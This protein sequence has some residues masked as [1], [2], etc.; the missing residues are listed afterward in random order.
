TIDDLLAGTASDS[1]ITISG[2]ATDASF[3][4]SAAVQADTAGRVFIDH[5]NSGD[6][7][8]RRCNTEK[9]ELPF[10]TRENVLTLEVGGIPA[11]GEVWTLTV[12]DGAKTYKAESVVGFRGSLATIADD[13]ADNLA[14]VD[15]PL[16]PL[17]FDI[18]IVGLVMVI[19]ALDDG[20]VQASAEITTTGTGPTT[21]IFNFADTSGTSTNNHG[22]SQVQTFL[23]FAPSNWDDA[24]T[25]IVAAIDDDFIDGGDALVFP[26]F[27]ERVNLI[28]GPLNVIGG[29]SEAGDR[30]INDPFGLPDETNFLL[31]EGYV[32]ETTIV[33]LDVPGFD[34]ND[35]IL[36][37]EL[38]DHV[39]ATT[40]ERPG[41]DPRMND[42]DYVVTFLDPV[43]GK[44][45]KVDVARNGVTADI[46]S[47]LNNK[48]F[49][50]GTFSGPG[51][52]IFRGTP[53]QTSVANIAWTQATLNL[54][55]VGRAENPDDVDDTA[56][57]W[58]VTLTNG[59]ARDY[60]LTIT[61]G[62]EA[63]ARTALKLAQVISADTDAGYTARVAIGILGDARLVITRDD[64]A[65]F[66]VS[67]T[68]TAATTGPDLTDT[69]P[70]PGPPPV[71]GIPASDAYLPIG[72]AFVIGGTPV[73][74]DI[75]D[76]EW[77]NAAWFFD[78][79]ASLDGTWTINAGTGSFSVTNPSSIADLTTQ[80][81]SLIRRYDADLPEAR[82]DETLA[83][84]ISGTTVTFDDPWPEGTIPSGF[85]YSIT[86]FNPN[87]GVDEVDQVDT[88]TV[89]HGNSPAD[90][91]G[92][93]T[94]DRLIGLGMGPDAVIGGR[95][96]DGGISFSAL[97]EIFIELGTGDNHFVIE[98]T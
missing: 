4:A 22:V 12:V 1:S 97:E 28:R 36:F 46:V 93:L 45:T 79:Q 95:L 52:I 14:D 63:A 94:S 47:V 65:T 18:L 11:E 38:A 55:G 17:P 23:T 31:A 85:E 33:L 75:D 44:Q 48:P 84:A 19:S 53:V 86:P 42:F 69:P 68:I 40:G 24:Q 90:D 88:L 83:P 67:T 57:I 82:R 13:W 66:S 27:E 59:T 9:V 39:N 50:V 71:D 54:T 7:E 34:E 91:I 43:T 73:V 62:D 30:S 64:G 35:G 49:A 16:A 41:F 58:T 51:D 98:S 29:L 96:I 81:A 10:K 5:C 76:H 87:E 6:L 2:A 26:A 80:L 15:A 56:E 32:G 37:D 8:D 92:Y 21:K 78:L 72:G 61:A 3:F 20:V 70:D 74:D 25:V 60:S 77:T 89:S